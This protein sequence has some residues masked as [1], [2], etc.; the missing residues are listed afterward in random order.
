VVRL[1]VANR[2]PFGRKDMCCINGVYLS[3]NHPIVDSSDGFCKRACEVCPPEETEVDILYHFEIDEGH[4]FVLINGTPVMA[5]GIEFDGFNP[6]YKRLFASNWWHVDNDLRNKWLSVTYN[7]NVLGPRAKARR[8]FTLLEKKWHLERNVR[9]PN[10]A[11]S[12]QVYSNYPSF[13]KII[14]LGRLPGVEGKEILSRVMSRVGNDEFE[15]N[16]AAGCIMGVDL[17]SLGVISESQKRDVLIDVYDE[18][19]GV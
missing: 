10:W 5:L 16:R 3:P 15:Y 17:D 11:L 12:S 4:S 2:V 8:V 14:E 18:F 7:T 6:K 19:K 13:N 9:H 1:I